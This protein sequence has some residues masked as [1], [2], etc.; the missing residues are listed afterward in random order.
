MKKCK[1]P[2][3]FVPLNFWHSEGMRFCVFDNK[4]SEPKAFKNSCTQYHSW[5]IE[6]LEECVKRGVW[7]EIPEE[8][9]ALL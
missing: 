9:A 8:E 7:K 3:F 5:T 4:N 2:R 1:Y 6:E